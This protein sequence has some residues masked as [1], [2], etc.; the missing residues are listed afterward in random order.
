MGVMKT[1]DELYDEVEKE[2]RALHPYEVPEIAA[3]KADKVLRAYSVGQM[4][5]SR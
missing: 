2:I 5:S 1:Q 3:M 4:R